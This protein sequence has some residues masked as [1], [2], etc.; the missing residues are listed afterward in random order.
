M[1]DFIGYLLTLLQRGMKLAV[2][3]AL[4]CA[5]CLGGAWLLFRRRGR[6]FP[7]GKAIVLILLVGWAALT[8]YA[9]LM[10]G[11]GGMYREWNLQLFL[12]WREAWNR[13]T[14]QIWLNVLLNIALFVP[15]GLLLPLLAG[16]FRRW[17]AMLAAGFGTSLVIEL[18]QLAAM[19]GMFDVDDLFTNTLG[20]MLGWGLSVAILAPI[21]RE[22]GWV[23][24]CLSGLSV[25][26]VFGLAMGGLFGAYA[27]KPYGNLPEGP[28]SRADLSH[29]TW[30][31]NFTPSED[32]A[33]ACIYQA[34]R[35]DRADSD[36]FAAE[37][38]DRMGVEFE[39]V[40]Y[41]DDLNWYGNHSTGD[42][43]YVRPRDGTWEYHPG[44]QFPT[45]N[46]PPDQVIREEL[47]A[48]LG[49]MGVSVPEEAEMTVE[50]F[51]EAITRAVFTVDQTGAGE[52]LLHGTLTCD[53]SPEE[54]GTEL[55]RVEN[56]L[57]T[58][59]PGPEEEILSPAQAVKALCDGRSSCGLIL[60]RE[61]GDRIRV[62]DC[63]LDWT[64]DTKGFYQPVYQITMQLENGNEYHDMVPALP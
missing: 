51:G 10:R 32:P 50:P 55:Y 25:I 48:A 47:T 54:G 31:V 9:T 42:F 26:L 11:E 53:L 1:H 30:E 20:A 24:Q 61:G 52:Q 18:A 64:A 6:P 38:A 49:T 56:R 16:V 60:E 27:L 4:L 21:R 29:V 14:L 12:A 62:L 43:L 13:F 37:F 40:I 15:L 39:D 46:S 17:Y 28:V 8:A 2:P 41:Y 63:R 57:V 7:W 19:R 22:R 5:L 3:A 58:L 59:T 33:A 36:A 23:R 35:M 45:L 34:G 44:R